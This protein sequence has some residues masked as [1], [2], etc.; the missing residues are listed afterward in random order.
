MPCVLI[1][2]ANA[3]TKPSTDAVFGMYYM[4]VYYLLVAAI[5]ILFRAA[6]HQ[7]GGVEHP[8]DHVNVTI[9]EGG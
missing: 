8:V 9:Y 6:T 4:G 5:K 7:S 1:R 2:T 3:V